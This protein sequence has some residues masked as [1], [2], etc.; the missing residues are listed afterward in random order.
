MKVLFKILFLLVLGIGSTTAQQAV[1]SARLDSMTIF[2]GGQV[3]LNIDV[4]LP[5]TSDAQMIQLKD[6]LSKDVEIVES[7]KIDTVVQNG[8]RKLSQRYL[9]TSFDTGLFYV[10]PFDI[11]RYADGT[12]Q[13]ADGFALQVLNPF[14]SIEIDEQTGVAHITDIREPYDAPFLL[15]ELLDYWPWG[16]GVLLLIGAIILGRYLY[17]RYRQNHTDTPKP[18]KEAPKEPCHITALRK[19]EQ[20][21]EEGLWKRNM[22]KEYFSEI[23]DTLRQYISARYD[24]RAMESTSN[25]IKESLKD[26]LR[27]APKSQKQL[28][29]ILDLADL[30]KF[31]KYE[32]LPDENDMTIK[33]AIDF[34]NDTTPKPAVPD[35][36]NSKKENNN[37]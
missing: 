36:N 26:V 6:S 37:E 22:F 34:V 14:Q 8:I 15:S 33:R 11:V 30:V 35:D 21:K 25:E 20:I 23:T 9:I 17:R 27:D 5:E 28:D 16:V 18:K 29:E 1:V 24:V 3:G 2:I 10:P 12:T 19:L 7:L 13:K 4:S 31:A 32:P